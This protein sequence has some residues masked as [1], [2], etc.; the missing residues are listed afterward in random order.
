MGEDNTFVLVSEFSEETCAENNLTTHI[1]VVEDCNI[2][3][4]FSWYPTI[5]DN[6]IKYPRYS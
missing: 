3:L 2:E 1:E 4:I 5:G 6:I